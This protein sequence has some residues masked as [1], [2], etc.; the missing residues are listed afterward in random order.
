MDKVIDVATVTKLTRNLF[1]IAVIP[2]VSYLYYK[3][4]NQQDGRQT[5]PKWYKFVPIFVLLFLGLSLIRTLGDV[6]L[7][8]TGQAFSLLARSSWERFY[9]FWSSVGSTYMLGIAMAGVGLSTDF[10]MFKGLG[11]KPF[12]IGLTAAIT[13]GVISLTLVSLFG[14]FVQI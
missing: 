11:M 13:I 7:E 14:D 1:I 6:T 4:S 8:N 10:S 3:Q 9:E 2:F 12:Y 5:L